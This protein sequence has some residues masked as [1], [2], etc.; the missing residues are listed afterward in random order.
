[1]MILSNP[2]LIKDI[3]SI[4]FP[5]LNTVLSADLM[6]ILLLLLYLVRQ[7]KMIMNV[8]NN[9]DVFLTFLTKKV[10]A[11]SFKCEQIFLHP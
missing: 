5:V 11:K 8:K 4:C 9:D 10:N 1:M 6:Q 3:K 2:G 7:K